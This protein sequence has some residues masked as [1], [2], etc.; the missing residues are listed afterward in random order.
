MYFYNLY[1]S[2]VLRVFSAIMDPFWVMLLRSES[3]EYNSY[4]DPYNRLLDLHKKKT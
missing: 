2:T 3:D 4:H 1:E